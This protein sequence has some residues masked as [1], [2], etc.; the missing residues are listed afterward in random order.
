MRIIHPHPQAGRQIDL[1]VTFIDGVATVD[2]LHPVRELAL[3][4]HGYTIEADPEVEAPFQA[5]LGEPI[6][7]LHSLTVPELLDIAETEGVDVPAKAR[8]P[9]IIDL[10]SG[11]PAAPIADPNAV[12]EG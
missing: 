9:E 3:R 10:L 2:Q 1:G 11:Q 4:Q 12:Q 7:D 5:D 8:K 6:I